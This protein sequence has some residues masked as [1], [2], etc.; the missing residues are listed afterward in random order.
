[1]Y[2]CDE[3]RMEDKIK[4]FAQFGDAGHGGITRYSLSEEAIQA[5]DEFV[6]RMQAIGATI[7]TDD[8]AN[9]YA[10]IPGSDPNA[11][12]IVMG[13]HCDSVK[14]GGNYDGI[15]GVM[16]A[17]EVLETIVANQIP[18]KHPLTAV[19]FT[20]EEGS[21]FPPCMMCSG[22]LA[23][24]YMPERFRD[25]FAYEKMMQSKSILEPEM[26][27][28]KKLETFKYKGDIQNRMTPEKYQAMFEL[29]IEQGPILEDAGKDVGVVTCVLGQML[30][31][32]KFY[33][34]AAHAGT[35]PMKKRHDAFHAAA[36]AL[37]WLHD[38]IDQLGHED[39]VYTTGEVVIH[40]CVNTVIP[41]FFDF[42]IDVRHENPDVLNQVR[43]IL[44]K[45]PQKEWKGCRCEVELGW[46]RDTVYWNKELVGYVREAVEELG[47][48]HMDINSGAGHDAQ[49]ISYML[50]TT[51][52]FVP[53]DKG[54]SHCEPEHTSVKQC[55]QGASVLLNAVLKC[56]QKDET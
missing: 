13:S 1:M 41:D 30:Y 36:E 48:S 54:L 53:S 35:F 37:C 19:I 15:L 42:S 3:K 10:T 52:I 56:D 43:E 22:I 51:M 28:G 20:N 24:D 55:T 38:E 44:Q 23:H 21:E 33:G 6:R 49:Y 31:R 4:T 11:K 47:Y 16:G 34:Q 26:T 14:N 46:N 32:V 25:N 45:L 9:M 29:H 27:F 50:P 17:M 12:R 18:H 39:L 2:Q 5:R 7:E 8:L 40:P